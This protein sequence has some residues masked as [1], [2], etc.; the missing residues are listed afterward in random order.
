MKKLYVGIDLAVTGRHRGSVYDPQENRY[1]DNSFAFDI[2]FDGFEYMLRR[3]ESHAQEGEEV[4]LNFV[5]E[6]T[7]LAW[8]PLSCYLIS[9][10]HLVF[11]VTPQQSADF[12][13]LRSKHVKSD[14]VDCQ[15]LAKLPVVCE[16][17]VYQL[18]LPSS[19]L[20][21]LGRLARHMAKITQQ[22]ASR[23]LRIWSLFVMINPKI[24]AVFGEEKFSRTA[25]TMYRHFVDPFKIVNLGKEQF[26]EAFRSECSWDVA[27]EVLEKIYEV[28]LSTTKIYGPMVDQGLLPFN[29]GRVE[30]E[31]RIELDLMEAE[32]KK[33]S[34]IQHKIEPLYKRID[35]QGYLMSVQGIGI[36]IAAAILG[37]IGDVSR[38]PTIGA[39]RAFFGFTPK[40][41]QSSNRDQQGLSIHKAAQSLLKMY[42]F[43]AAETA[44]RY[45]PEFAAFY[46]RLTKR[47]L[48]HYQAACAL[49][50]KMSG[51]VYAL[52]K[53][54]QRAEDSCYRSTVES[55]QPIELL[56][57]AE[58]VYKLRDLEGNI[59]DKKTARELIV[60]K[61]PSISQKRR[62][63]KARKNNEKL[64]AK[65]D[66]ETKSRNKKQT[67][68]S[69][70]SAGSQQSLPDQP[71]QFPALMPENSSMRSG[72]TLPAGTI[73]D[74]MLSKLAVQ[75][76]LNSSGQADED[77][78]ELA[79]V[80]AGM[81]TAVDNLLIGGG[82]IN[83]KKT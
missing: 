34:E 62:E 43:L 65:Q 56:R 41:N 82:K 60:E 37:I 30:E 49:A 7:A 24:L 25:R 55:A 20:G 13:K 48:H 40:K 4:Q 52:L 35:P 66:A 15:A 2:N 12:R 51:R 76:Q 74:D 83:R 81:D 46:N 54:M 6:P 26:A 70:E 5:M 29:Y 11:R 23:K 50:N 28:S 9:K 78:S 69:R 21:E 77:L 72:R 42:M 36:V 80:Q 16:D 47:G 19:D 63:E 68:K 18:Y 44:R 58:V 53:R 64:A 79:N 22:A 57:S 8:M 3:V 39:F 73:L 45:D 71:R 67:N 27:D 14:R 75:V 33:I 38:F 10:G 31:V 59:I 61:F 32:E 1:L 17:G